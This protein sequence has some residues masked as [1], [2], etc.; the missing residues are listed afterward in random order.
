MTKFF[1]AIACLLATAVTNA[2]TVLGTWQGTLPITENPRIILKL[3]KAQ[4]GAPRGNFYWIDKWDNPIPLSS[5]SFTAPNLS[6]A[7]LYVGTSYQAKLSEDGKSLTGTWTQ[8]KKTYP[9][10]LQLT[11]PAN[12]WKHDSPVTPV[13]WM[14]ETADPAFEVATIKPSVPGATQRSFG[15]RTR[16]FAAK[17]STVA[18]LLKYAYKV[19]SRQIEGAPDWFDQQ[20]FDIAAEPDTEGQPSEDQYRTMLK[21]LLA[22][23][24]QLKLHTVQKIFPVYALTVEKNPPKLEPS[25][26]S[27]D[28]HGNI[29]TGQRDS[30]MYAQFMH[31]SM[32]EFADVLMNFIPER[33]IVDETG[34][35]GR[36]DFAMNMPMSILQSSDDNEKA[37]A[38]FGAVQP[39][40]FK[41][42]PKKA[43]LEVLVIDHLEAPSSN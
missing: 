17:N 7:S 12:V 1:L 27:V 6:I 29:V 35:T 33:Q 38:F 36:F 24:F 28:Q 20:R 42:V 25:E 10:T 41:L 23:R 21:K 37:A 8:D 3:V 31:E 2:Q 11:P 32:F 16:H 13:A 4:D 26:P 34:L 9:L 19:R 14:S 40:G 43:P 18:D 15:L 30:Q 22:D 39:L 5:V